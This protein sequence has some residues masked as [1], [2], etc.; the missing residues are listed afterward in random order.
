MFSKKHQAIILTGLLV[1]AVVVW[2]FVEV[3]QILSHHEVPRVV[4]QEVAPLEPKINHEVFDLLEK[5]Q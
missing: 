1:I 3:R 5:R 2:I 4:E